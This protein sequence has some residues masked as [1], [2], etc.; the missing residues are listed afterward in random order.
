MSKVE[1]LQD[2]LRNPNYKVK[3]GDRLKAIRMHR[4]LSIKRLVQAIDSS[5]SHVSGVENGTDTCKASYFVSACAYM[6]IHPLRLLES[7]ARGLQFLINTRPVDDLVSLSPESFSPE[8]VNTTQHL[9]TQGFS[10][11]RRR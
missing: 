4:G 10:H 5:Q 11:G 8:V 3:I 9:L 1:Q 2:D 6:G 7:S